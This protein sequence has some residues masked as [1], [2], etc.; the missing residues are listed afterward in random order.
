M[1]VKKTKM[2]KVSTKMFIYNIKMLLWKLNEIQ[3]EN[4]IWK[5][6]INNTE[7]KIEINTNY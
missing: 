1:T 3:H 5:L 4:I 2:L 7:I 6:L